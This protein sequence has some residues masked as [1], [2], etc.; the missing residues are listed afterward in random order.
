M[1]TLLT[2]GVYV[3]EV[4]PTARPITGVGTSTAAFFGVANVAPKDMP[5]K[6]SSP[7]RFSD[8]TVAYTNNNR[9]VALTGAAWPQIP[10]DATITINGVPYPVESRT[11]DTVLVLPT[12]KNPGADVAAGAKYE[13]AVVDRYV[14]GDAGKPYLITSWEEFK[15]HFG[16]FNSGNLYLA[17]AVYGFFNN[18]GT[19]CFVTRLGAQGD[20]DA[21]LTKAAAIDEIALVAMPL[22]PD[23]TAAQL[24]S[25]QGKLLDHCQGLEDRFAILDSAKAVANDNLVVTGDA[26]GIWVPGNAQGYGAFYFPWVE[27]SDPLGT[28]GQTILVPPC[29]HLAGVY[30]RS[31]ANRGVFKAPA[32]EQLLG[33]RGLAYAVTKGQQAGLNSR[34][35]NCLRSFYGTPLVWGARTVA[36]A[37]SEFRYVNVRRFMNFL[38]ESIIQGVAWAV[39]EPNSPALW[40]SIVRSVGDF[41]LGQWRDGA[42]FGDTPQQAFYVRCDATTNPPDVREQGQV[43]TEVGVAVVKPAEFIVFR[44]QQQTGG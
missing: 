25:V 38:R 23:A 29:G 16:D 44:I 19:R 8:G 33:V 37:S 42:L 40:K 13:L 24:N 27:V 17:H 12:G 36:P 34:G 21:A 3:I 11:S 1:A 6:P 9:Q 28:A 30:A 18:G 15:Q 26:T 5:E 7:R 22:A 43:V 31:D 4:P 39:F 41:L 20:L 32:N 35:V 14:Q 2:P 10:T